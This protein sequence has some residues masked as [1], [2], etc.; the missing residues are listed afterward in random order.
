MGETTVPCAAV[1][2][3]QDVTLVFAGDVTAA[4]WQF[5]AE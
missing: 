2:G 5:A 4:W 3:T 1:N